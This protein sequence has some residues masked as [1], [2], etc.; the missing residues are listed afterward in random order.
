MN[1]SQTADLLARAAHE[2]MRGRWPAAVDLYTEAYRAT[3][4]Q[5]DP[6]ALGEVVIRLGHCLRQAG[7]PAAAAETLELAAEMA[8]RWQDLGQAARALNGLAILHQRAGE[9]D[10]AE[11]I[12]YRA[13]EYVLRI[14]DRRGLGEIEQNL[15]TL[16]NTR[17]NLEAARQHYLDGLEHLEAAGIERPIAAA[18]NNLGML[19]IDLRRFDD[20]GRYFE[21]ALALAERLGDVVTAGA[22]HINRTE[23]FLEQG[24]PHLARMSCDEGFEIA[25]RLG[26]QS[27]RAEALKFY[28]IIYR[29]LKKLHLAL[30]HLNQAIEASMGREPL[31]E[32][33]AQR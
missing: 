12:Y 1:D 19:H 8:E 5:K 3:I 10:E 2:E 21:R 22:I 31:L 4:A 14:G 11:A 15:G 9:I 30:S 26:D 25:S 28:G 18:L 27:R 24:E 23:L 7:N 17:G 16:D 6:Q 32:A 33:E 29:H 13:R 20:A